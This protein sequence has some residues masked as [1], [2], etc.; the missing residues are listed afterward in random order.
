MSWGTPEQA[1]PLPSQR[2]GFVGGPAAPNAVLRQGWGIQ[3]SRTE[4]SAGRVGL[5]AAVPR[6]M[7]ETEKSAGD[8]RTKNQRR[9]VEWLE[10][11]AKLCRL[12]AARVHG[13]PREP[14][15]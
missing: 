13:L 6:T 15:S 11:P 14:T 2:S 5:S 10:P 9:Q 1:A 12:V 3:E 8:R 4:R 7:E